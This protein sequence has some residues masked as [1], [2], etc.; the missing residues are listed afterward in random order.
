[1]RLLACCCLLLSGA[2]LADSEVF[3][4]WSKDGTW[5]VYEQHTQ[6]DRMELYFCSTEI[7]TQPTW[8]AALNQ[9]DRE[10]G[11]LSCVRFL[12]PNKA[13]YQWKNLLVLPAPS[14][15]QAGINIS[16]ELST[17]GESPGFTLL[18]GDK[19]QS[20]YASATHEDS[21]LQKTWFHPSSRFV[22]ALI[23]GNFRHC[24]VTL[25]P[26]KTVVKPGGKK[27]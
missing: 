3:H 17:D 14:T 5:L 6:D 21:K 4:G 11:T 22:A 16:S 23:D 20:C 10:D 9:L 13:P 24:V 27:K 12:D 8:P 7:Q 15:S 2:A 1:M 18:S 26:S 19:K 25:K